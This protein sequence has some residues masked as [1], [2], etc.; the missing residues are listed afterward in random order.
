MAWARSRREPPV[1]ASAVPAPM[2]RNMKPSWLTVPK[3]SR[4]LRSCWRSAR[5]P[6]ASI[7]TRPTVKTVGRQS[8][9][10]ANAGERRADEVDAGG[11]HGGGVEVGADRGR[12]HHGA[13][14]PGVEGVLGRL[15]H[16]AEEHEDEGHGDR[17]ARRRRRHDLAEPVG[18][19]GLPEEHEA[20]EHGQTTG[21]GDQQGLQ[22]RGPGPGVGVVVADEEV[23]RDRRELPERV[24]EEEVVGDD[25]ADHGAGEQRQQT[26][27][28]PHAGPLPGQVPGGVGEHEDAD[29]RHDEHH[30]GREAVDPDVEVEAELGDP[31]EA[32]LD[33][34]AVEQV[35]QA[36]GQP[37]QRGRPVPR[38]RAPGP[39]VPA[40][41]R[42][43][44]RRCRGW[45]RGGSERA[46]TDLWSVG[47]RRPTPSMA[48][49][50]SQERSV[51]A[52]H[53]PEPC[54]AV[55]P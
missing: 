54:R 21:A 55:R 13:R 26:D 19:G 9:S 40:G 15:R 44:S 31:G 51:D 16:R 34:L 36:D 30:Q 33:R 2:T 6:P 10:E 3:A 37:E 7:V 12:G 14:Q 18:A 45:R 32:L 27:Q 24:E 41:S 23:R 8:S 53:P 11:D 42:L 29:A 39:A 5:S 49:R 47:W 28:A 20:D 38:P 46:S 50:G 25:Q 1:A 17:R 43:R 48:V 52:G 35:G 4:S 22:G